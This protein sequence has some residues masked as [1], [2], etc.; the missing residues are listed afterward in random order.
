MRDIKL[1]ISGILRGSERMLYYIAAV[2][3]IA[4][5]GF[6]CVATALDIPTLLHDDGAFRTAI[7]VLDRVLLIFI[8]AE[9]LH[10]IRVILEEDRILVEPFLLIGIIAVIRRILLASAE[11]TLSGSAEDFQ[12]LIVE[13]AVLSALVIALGVSFY[14][15]RRVGR[16]EVLDKELL[17]KKG[18]GPDNS[19]GP[20]PH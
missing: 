5:V 14:L 11:T 2:A 15:V 8:F 16:Q 4:T 17:E 18:R 6:L 7:T 9:L 3:L 10:S 12:R 20:F 19:S 1:T 13:L